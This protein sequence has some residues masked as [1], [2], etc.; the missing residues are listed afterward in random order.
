MSLQYTIIHNGANNVCPNTYR[1][2]NFLCKNTH[3]HTPLKYNLIH[4]VYTNTK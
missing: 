1:S 3:T 2:V 4:L